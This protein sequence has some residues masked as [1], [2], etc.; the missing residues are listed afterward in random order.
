MK[1]YRKRF[2]QLNMLLIGIVLTAVMLL[3][4]VYMYRDYTRG[5]RNTMEQMVEPLNT[6]ARGVPEPGVS[7]SEPPPA[8]RQEPPEEKGETD[9]SRPKE[10]MTVFYTPGETPAVLSSTNLFDEDTLPEIL[11]AV[12]GQGRNF[13]ILSEY[14]AIYYCVGSGSP[15]KIALA[16]TGYILHSMAGLSLALCGVWLGAMLCF[17]WVS[18]RLSR[19]A[20]RPMEQAMQR[21]KQFV[22]DA[23]HDLKTPLSVILANSSILRENPGATIAE[24]DRWLISTQDA[25]KNMQALINEMLTLAAAERSDTPLELQQLDAAPIVTKAVLQLESLAYE[26]SVQLETEIPDLLPLR[27]NAD[28]LERVTASLTENAIKYEPGGGTVTIRLAAL[29]RKVR[30]E[31]QNQHATISPQDLPHVF[32]RFYRAD[33]SRTGH[34]NSHGLGL[35]IAQQMVQRMGGQ[36]N[37]RSDEASGAIFYADF[38]V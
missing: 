34:A 9:T 30:L 17:L 14:H 21:E 1:E 26:K 35:A 29:H 31:V 33:K 15:Y 37:V 27:T 25:A 13:G 20:V 2:V 22:A 32:D 6:I 8:N 7:G 5:L 16:S 12:I 19:A 36:L 38:P 18:I 11:T 23:S 28:Y 10:I 4:A 3:I 24:V